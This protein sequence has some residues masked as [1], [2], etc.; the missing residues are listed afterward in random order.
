MNGDSVSRRFALD[1]SVIIE[2]LLAS[3]L[4]KEFVGA[5]TSEL[6]EGKTS[7]VNLAEAEYILCRKLGAETA[8]EKISNLRDSNY[9]M[10]VDTEQASRIA[11]RIKCSRA[12]AL[13]D[14]YTLATA[15]LAGL[16]AL[17][18]FREAELVHEI[19]KRPLD[20]EVVFLEDLSK[21]L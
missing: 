1:S 3:D 5:L 13:A 21:S 4:S 2:M 18:A 6:V 11:A 19:E 20:V 14:C 10:V 15:K 12:L 8:R 9:V 17:F 16:K 7:E